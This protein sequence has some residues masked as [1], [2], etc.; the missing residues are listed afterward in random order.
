MGARS[1]IS[2]YVASATNARNAAQAAQGTQDPTQV[3]HRAA[4]CTEPNVE[5]MPVMARA[6]AEAV[7]EDSPFFDAEVL[8]SK[9]YTAMVAV[10]DR[11]APCEL[12]ST[13][14]R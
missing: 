11:T 12:S 2:I 8:A 4:R 9:I 5:I 7:E 13:E 14:T 6:D 10:S 1:V 3:K